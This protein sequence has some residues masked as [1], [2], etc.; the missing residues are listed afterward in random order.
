VADRQCLQRG[1]IGWRQSR[2][3]VGSKDATPSHTTP[4]GTAVAS[5]ISEIGGA[6]QGVGGGCV[7]HCQKSSKTRIATL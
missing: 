2:Q 3:V 7:V 6:L 4:L 5:Q 1:Y